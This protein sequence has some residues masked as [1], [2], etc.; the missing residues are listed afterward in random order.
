MKGA[1]LDSL[2]NY[3]IKI[4]QQK[5]SLSTR[6]KVEKESLQKSKSLSKLTNKAD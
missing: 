4:K 2:N 5:R 1:V 6:N 3:P